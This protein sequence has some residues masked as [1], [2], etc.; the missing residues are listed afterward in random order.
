LETEWILQIPDK[1]SN[2][3]QLHVYWDNRLF[4]KIP[5]I[6]TF[7]GQTFCITD[8]L[9]T[10]NIMFGIALVFFKKTGSEYSV[11]GRVDRGLP[12]AESKG[13]LTSWVITLA[14]QP[15]PK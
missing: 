5:D 2:I 8:D 15:M 4:E 11:T 1:K 7:L 13:S 6:I 14:R 3:S 12:H 10:D 9:V